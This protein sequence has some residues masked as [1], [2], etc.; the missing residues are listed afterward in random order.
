MLNIN[1]INN[2]DLSI[3]GEWI[4]DKNLNIINEPFDHIIIDNFLNL[5]SFNKIYDEI[6]ELNEDYYEYYNPIEIKYT[7]NKIDKLNTNIK[8]L[9]N[10]LSNPKIIQIFSKLFNINDLEYDSILHGAGIHLQPINGRLNMHL[11]YEKHPILINKQ[12][13]LNIIIYMN[14]YWDNKWCGDT[15]LWDK[16]MKNCIVKSFPVKNRVLIFKTSEISWHGVPDK[17]K[18]PNNIFRKTLAYYYISSITNKSDINKMGA[19]ENGYRE[20]AVFI[21]RPNDNYDEKIEKLYKIRPYRRITKEDLIELYGENYKN[22][23]L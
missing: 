4:N 23:I 3:F 13:C 1:D 20:K 16:D 21:K 17:I 6:P 22:N 15:Q 14:K 5:N 19:N 9:F 2:A 11:D 8:N 7:H 18:C 10:A 12:R